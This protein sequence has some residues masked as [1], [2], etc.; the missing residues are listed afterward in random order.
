MFY[1]MICGQLFSFISYAT[2]HIIRRL[3]YKKLFPRLQRV[4]Q[5]E[6]S[7]NLYLNRDNRDVTHSHK[8]IMPRVK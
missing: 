2:S 3:N 7:P 4:P 5:R 1:Y 6:Q 8:S